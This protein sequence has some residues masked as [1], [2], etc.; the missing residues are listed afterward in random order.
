VVVEELT[1]RGN[2]AEFRILGIDVSVHWTFLLILLLG[3]V[4]YGAGPGGWLLG[5][6]YGVATMLLVF[7]G[8]TLHEFGHALAA[9]FY[10]IGTRGIT[11]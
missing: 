4:T 9:R 2:I 7:V 11:L 6:L 5:G 1:M 8:V 10:G 3:A